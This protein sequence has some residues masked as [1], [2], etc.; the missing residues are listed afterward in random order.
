MKKIYLV[1]FLAVSVLGFA[2]PKAKQ[3]YDG[4]SAEVTASKEELT[5]AVQDIVGDGIIQGSKEYEKDPY[6]SGASQV[7]DCPLFP[8]WTGEGKVFCKV[9]TDA[10]APRNF[11]DSAASGTLAV[12]Y[13]VQS[14]D[15]TRCILKIDALYVESEHRFIHPS[16]GTVE[17]SEYKD[18]Q[19]HV[20]AIQLQKKQAIEGANKRQEELARRSLESNSLPDAVEATGQAPQTIK[21]KVQAMRTKLERT[22]AAQGAALKAAPYASAAK[23]SDLTGGTRVL[24]V[25]VS[26]YWLGVETQNGQHGWIRHDQL[27]AVE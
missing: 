24:I 26:P 18:I 25:V 6:V 13:I 4:F 20:D 21:Q 1:I 22:V 5:E 2:T 27:D 12:R 17:T 7:D 15:A 11:V 14:K 16:N 8:K 19:D 3:K 9:R 23:L 10:I